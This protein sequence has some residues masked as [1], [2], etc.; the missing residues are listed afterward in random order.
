MV[1][2]R[3]VETD[4]V[5]VLASVTLICADS[6]VYPQLIGAGQPAGAAAATRQGFCVSTDAIFIN[7]ANNMSLV[8]NSGILG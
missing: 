8:L 6:A 5:R 7:T 4:V 2:F 3:L 1:I